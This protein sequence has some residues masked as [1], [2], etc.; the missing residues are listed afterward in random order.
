MSRK[1]GTIYEVRP[2]TFERQRP[3]PFAAVNFYLTKRKS[4]DAWIEGETIM[5]TAVDET[6]DGKQQTRTLRLALRPGSG[7]GGDELQI[8]VLP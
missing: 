5:L 7:R 4:V 2:V 6:A 8:E 3:L 1:P